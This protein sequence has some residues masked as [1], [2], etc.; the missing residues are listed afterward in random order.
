MAPA[1][2]KCRPGIYT[3]SPT[4]SPKG[5]VKKESKSSKTRAEPLSYSSCIEKAQTPTPTQRQHQVK[6]L[7]HQLTSVAM[8]TWEI[9]VGNYTRKLRSITDQSTGIY[10]RLST[11]NS[12]E[13]RMPV[14]DDYK[15]EADPAQSLGG[16]SNHNNLSILSMP[17]P[18]NI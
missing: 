1:D 2:L 15:S 8:V 9:M 12:P 5:L 11:F 7:I 16:G 18:R 6:Q 4:P 10:R 13:L 3:N 14:P 17:R